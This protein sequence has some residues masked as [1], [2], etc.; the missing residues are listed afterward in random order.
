M[1]FDSSAPAVTPL[2]R[3]IT[4]EIKTIKDKRS[5]V[6]KKPYGNIWMNGRAYSNSEDSLKSI[7]QEDESTTQKQPWS[8]EEIEVALSNLPEGNKVLSLIPTLHGDAL[9][10]VL[11]EFQCVTLN[12]SD[13]DRKHSSIPLSTDKIKQKTTVVDENRAANIT[14]R[15][16]LLAKWPNTCLLISSWLGHVEIV[17]TLLEKGVSVSTR[18]NDGRTPLHLAA[19]TMSTKIVEELLKHGADPCE[20]DFKKKYTPLHCAAAAGCVATVTCLIK[21]GANVNAR[22][23]PLYYAVLNNAVDCVEALLQAGA[24]PNNPQFY[25]RM[26]LHVAASLGNVHCIKLLLDHGADVRIKMRTT[27]STPLHL[28]A[29]NGNA[30]CTS[31]LLKA[32][33]K[34]ETKN[35]SGQTAMHLAT[36]AKSVETIKELIRFGAKVDE[37]DNEGRTPLHAAVASARQSSELV[38]T[39]INAGASVNKADKFGYT[40]LHIAALNESSRTVMMLLSKGGDV[41]ARTKDGIT[42][43]SFIVRRTPEVLSQL[44][45]RLD[46]SVSLHYHE[47]GD[48]DC[49][50]R[51][52]FRPLIP[53]GG[54]NETDLMLCLVEVGV[55]H[56]LKHPLCQSFL[57]LKWKRVRKFFLLNFLFH[58]I[59]FVFFV[60]FICA[61]YLWHNEQLS[62]VLFWPVL[63]FTCILASK[64]LFQITVYGIYHYTKRWGNWLQWSVI[65]TYSIILISP[66]RPWQHH[67]AAIGI[68]L[69]WIELIIVIGY[70]PM[71]GLYI[72]ML[73]RVSINFFKL[74]TAYV[75]LIIGF[76]FGF[77]MLHNNYQSFT[78]PLISILKMIIMMSGELEFEDICLLFDK[79]L[80]YPGSMYF[81]FFCF[82]LLV[83]IILMNLM[84]GLAVS[85]IQE[86]RKRANLERLVHHVEVIAHFENMLFSKLFDYT[87][88]CKIIQACRKN[89]LLLYSSND[90]A[91]YIRPNDPREKHLPRE[92]I[93]SLYRL[94][95]EQKMRDERLPAH[96]HSKHYTANI[97]NHARLSRTYSNDSDQQHLNEIMAELKKCSRDISITLYSLTYKIESI[98]RDANLTKHL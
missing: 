11:E 64:E 57:Y 80:K 14:I 55:A 30:K 18:D 46:Q 25:R 78:N 15:G 12:K 34:T 86:L 37:E 97:S 65:V 6:K 93:Q 10:K 67:V 5:N 4:Q 59:F 89:T 66:A 53:L 95:G 62:N 82:L 28:A 49:E 42:A 16:Q 75:V 9:Q 1:F 72:Q 21:S 70:F 45:T 81:I 58:F 96:H 31:L 17:K 7:E 22:R 68:L 71:F 51:V 35:S 44:P 98:V 52:D 29:E 63:G 8:K 90:C 92:L 61:A 39:L 76:A 56:M 91:L 26:P 24:S 79:D 47:L 3:R 27:K 2:I 74:F 87:H 19:C 23:S 36:I 40:P 50:L 73:T 84:I 32:G 41:T 48:M 88:A 69:A 43:L 83:T 13:E 60:N 38:K 33:S 54:R 94:A 77:N 20:W 85:D